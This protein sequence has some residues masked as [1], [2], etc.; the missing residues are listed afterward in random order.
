M[1]NLIRVLSYAICILS[2]V[3]LAFGCTKKEKTY[4]FTQGDIMVIYENGYTSGALNGMMYNYNKDVWK[5]D[6]L[7]MVSRWK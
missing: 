6:S 1:K 4:P 5:K 7:I 2:F 3:V